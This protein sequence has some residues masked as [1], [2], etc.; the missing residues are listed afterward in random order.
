M[1]EPFLKHPSDHTVSSS[2]AYPG[3]AIPATTTRRGHILRRRKA[4]CLF[5][6]KIHE[7]CKKHVGIVGLGLGSK[8]VHVGDTDSQEGILGLCKN[9]A[10][11][12][13][14]PCLH[15]RGGWENWQGWGRYS[16]IFATNRSL[17][18]QVGE[19]AQGTVQAHYCLAKA[20]VKLHLDSALQKLVNWSKCCFAA[21]TIKARNFLFFVIR[22]WSKSYPE[23]HILPGARRTHSVLPDYR[24]S[25]RKQQRKC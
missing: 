13:G 2:Q 15:T 21:H 25:F 18:L 1:K 23:C 4:C 19:Q 14:D 11:F 6:D 16:S 5:L 24:P 22:S 7:P 17:I 9:G 10:A 12:W 8:L 3:Q 20:Q